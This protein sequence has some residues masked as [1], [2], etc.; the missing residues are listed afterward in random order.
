MVAENNLEQ[1]LIC[2]MAGAGQATASVIRS[3]IETEIIVHQESIRILKQ[4]I[5]QEDTGVSY[6]YDEGQSTLE[7]SII[8]AMEGI[9]RVS[10]DIFRKYRLLKIAQHERMIEELYDF[11]MNLNH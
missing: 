11:M 7:E 3:M 1:M 8:C 6:I 10:G 9:G 2:T 5:S 4:T